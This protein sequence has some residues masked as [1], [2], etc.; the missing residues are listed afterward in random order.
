MEK[1]E[2]FSEDVLADKIYNR[3]VIKKLLSYVLRYKA[4]G[5]L[6]IFLVVFVYL[7]L[8]GVSEMDFTSVDLILINS[9]M[10]FFF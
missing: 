10:N 1:E 6:S 9:W 7:Y 3:T 4:S 2:F 8:Q 5:L